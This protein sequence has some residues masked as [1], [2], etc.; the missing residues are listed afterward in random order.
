MG[1]DFS[2][3]DAELAAL[4]Q[5]P[6]NVLELAKSY[7]G[8][9]KSLK[10]VDAALSSLGEPVDPSRFAARL[11]SAARPVPKPDAARPPESKEISLPDQA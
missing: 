8:S 7:T 2:G 9:P 1:F 3:L 10:D 5:P 4:G 11:P 6:A